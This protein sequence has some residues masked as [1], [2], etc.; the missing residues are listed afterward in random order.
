MKRFRSP[1][2]LPGA[3]PFSRRRFIHPDALG[4]AA[5]GNLKLPPLPKTA[6]FLLTTDSGVPLSLCASRTQASGQVHLL[7]QGDFRNPGANAA[8]AEGFNIPQIQEF[9]VISENG[10]P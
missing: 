4:A 3:S 9:L 2:N 8:W 5:L 1:D 10:K 7:P 6:C